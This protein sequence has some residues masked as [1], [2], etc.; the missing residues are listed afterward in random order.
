VGT[1]AAA[2]EA[3]AAAFAARLADEMADT[4]PLTSEQRSA[5]SGLANRQITIR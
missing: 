4:S 3:P 1:G 5:R 2:L